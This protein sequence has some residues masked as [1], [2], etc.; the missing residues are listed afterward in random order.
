MSD[1]LSDYYEIY[2][3]GIETLLKV[4]IRP[5]FRTACYLLSYAY[6]LS[7]DSFHLTILNRLRVLQILYNSK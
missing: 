1:V 2:K 4:M 6:Y 5:L 3:V 7:I